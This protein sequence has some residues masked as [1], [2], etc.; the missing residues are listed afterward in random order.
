M[1]DEKAQLGLMHPG[2]LWISSRTQGPQVRMG[3][4]TLAG[5]FPGSHRA[6]AQGAVLSFR[7]STILSHEIFVTTIH[8]GGSERQSYVSLR[9]SQG[10]VEVKC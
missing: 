3:I 8:R 1:G 4:P 10:K 6:Q 9:C 2:R 5:E 7:I